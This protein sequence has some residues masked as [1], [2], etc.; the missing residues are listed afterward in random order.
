MDIKNIQDYRVDEIS[1]KID[2]KTT[3]F[4]TLITPKS[5]FQNVVVI[6]SGTGE[7]SQKAHNYLTEFLLRN[8]TG[9]FRFDKRGVGKSTGEYD[10]NV[11]LYTKDFSE[12]YSK[13]EEVKAFENKN[14]GFLGHSLGGI[15]SLQAIEKQVKPDFLIQWSAPVGKPRDLL[16]Y[17]INNGIKNYDQLIVGENSYERLKTLDYIFDLIDRN[18][19]KTAWDIWK[20]AKKESRKYGIDKKSFTNYI[21]PYHLELARIDNS[22]TLKKID[23]PVLV[24]I[25]EEDILVDP[26]QSKIKLDKIQNSNIT[27]KVLKELNH[28]MTK[29]GTNHKTNDIYNVD[30][31]FKN[32]LI[33]WIN[34]LEP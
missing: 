2:E 27:F 15:V 8:N 28:F 24:I 30:N 11:T 16:K 19:K 7:I 3:I 18:P 14:I 25:G 29:K 9:V 1:N 17:Q 33:G 20:I 26:I 5:D 10:D 31:S 4:G 32:Y 6:I 21:M 22:K 13:L 34:N 12:I 23:L